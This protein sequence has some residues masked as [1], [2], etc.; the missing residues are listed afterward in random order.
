M[1]VTDYFLGEGSS[2]CPVYLLSSTF[3]LLLSVHRLGLVYWLIYAHIYT[4]FCPPGGAFLS[5]LP[6]L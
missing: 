3:D 1:C 6:P 5:G 4:G 2:S